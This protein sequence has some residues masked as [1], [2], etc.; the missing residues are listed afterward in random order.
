MQ[1]VCVR[2]QAGG[3]ADTCDACAFTRVYVGSDAWHGLTCLLHATS[4]LQV[5]E[6]DNARI[7]TMLAEADES[8]TKIEGALTEATA[9][10]ARLESAIAVLEDE[11]RSRQSQVLDV[12]THA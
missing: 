2:S 9:N 11:G 12:Q 3:G 7:R 10:N 5:L 1:F 6:K 4:T 8:R